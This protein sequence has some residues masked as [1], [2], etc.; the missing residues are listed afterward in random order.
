[1]PVHALQLLACYRD[2][3]AAPDARTAVAAV[4]HA[5]LLP[6]EHDDDVDNADSCSSDSGARFLVELSNC[7]SKSSLQ[8]VTL[9]LPVAFVAHN[10]LHS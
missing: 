3:D 10:S 9:S 8:P 6:H 2:C 5:K 1:V 4:L 7:T